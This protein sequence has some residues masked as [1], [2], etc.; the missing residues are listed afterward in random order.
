MS[1]EGHLPLSLLLRFEEGDIKPAKSKLGM[2][3]RQ[4]PGSRHEGFDIIDFLLSA[5]LLW[6]VTGNVGR[7]ADSKLVRRRM[8]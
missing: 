3:L 5:S 2:R 6:R 1:D 7:Q 4:A 8:I